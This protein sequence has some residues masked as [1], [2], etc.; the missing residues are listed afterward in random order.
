MAGNGVHRWW[1]RMCEYAGLVEKGQRS[2]LNM[3]RS[4]HGF[5]LD[6]RRAAGLEAASHA[7]GHADLA[8]TMRH[9]GRWQDDELALAF[10]QVAATR[11]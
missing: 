4:R 3:H 6:M 11:K 8:T 10:E 7:L 5:A 1:Y 2:G 9:Y